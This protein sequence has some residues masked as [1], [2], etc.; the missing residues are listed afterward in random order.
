MKGKRHLALS[1][2]LPLPSMNAFPEATELL[3][4]NSRKQHRVNTA[5][6][7]YVKIMPRLAFSVGLFYKSKGEAFC[8]QHLKHF[9][10]Q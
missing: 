3:I 1:G 7:N 5:P 8:L 10:F 9:A 4:L 6:E 2:E